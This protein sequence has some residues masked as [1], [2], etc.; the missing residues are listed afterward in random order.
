MHELTSSCRSSVSRRYSPSQ[1]M[2]LP[3]TKHAR[4]SFVPIIPQMPR[5]QSC[6]VGKV[7]D[8]SARWGPEPGAALTPTAVGYNR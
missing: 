1:F 6:H 7:S 3:A 5:I 2:A 8:H 4:M